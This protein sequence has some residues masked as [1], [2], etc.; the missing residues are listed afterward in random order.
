MSYLLSALIM[1]AWLSAAPEGQPAAQPLRL[2]TRARAAVDAARTRVVSKDLAW[3]GTKTALIICDM[4]DAHWCKGATAR[5][6][7]LAPRMNA[8]AGAARERGV[9]VIH[10]PS[11]TMAAYENH[12]ARRRAVRAP[13][14][15]PTPESMRSWCARIPSEDKA[16][17]P[18][19]QSDGGC[20]CAPACRTGNPWRAQSAAI[21]IA[22]EDAIT[23]SGAEVWN[24]LRERGIT[25]VILAGV[26]TNMCVAG[27]PFGLRA[28]VAAGAN[29]VLIRDLTDTM[30]N[31]RARPHVSHFT[32]TD[33]VIEYIEEYICPTIVSS[34]LLG[35]APFRF[36]ADARPRVV[37]ISAENEYGAAESFVSF[38]RH[39]ALTGGAAAEILQAATDLAAPDA[40]HVP[41]MQALDTADCVVLF[42][43]RRAL[44]PDEMQCL[45]DYL[46]RGKPLIA[47]RTSSHGFAARG[48][49]PAGLA[50]WP[51]F[52]REVLGCRYDGHAGGGQIVRIAPEAG[53]HPVLDGLQGPYTERETLYRSAELAP[54]CSVLLVGSHTA[55]DGSTAA[56]AVPD[57][58]VAWTTAYRGAKV[59]YTSLGSGSASFT[60][61]WFRRMLV[62]A[63]F[64]A[65]SGDS[66]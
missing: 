1:G 38:S 44:P 12:P 37:F 50:Q 65:L 54:S 31:S 6:A 35:G 3:D 34:A 15:E 23:D 53:A 25:N 57:Q 10:A 5:V 42:A 59:F 4:W 33:L 66:H 43:R 49:V 8:F 30:Y 55:A 40:H 14:A 2:A 29:V 46:G 60:K 19:D 27:R 18:I 32:G 28:L 22:G 21:R 13:A 41:G 16:T 26:H 56:A 51:E 61:P 11:D 45:R 58:P 24:L 7:E 39:L 36:A 52:D 62:N 63:V 9:L 48:A 64:W 47:L 17:W 20:D